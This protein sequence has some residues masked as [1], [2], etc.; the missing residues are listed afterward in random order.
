MKVVLLQKSIHLHENMID[1]EKETNL[2]GKIDCILIMYLNKP[3]NAHVAFIIFG[4]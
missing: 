4:V 2:E 1:K 3:G